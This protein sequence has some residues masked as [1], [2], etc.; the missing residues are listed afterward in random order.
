MEEIVDA[1]GNPIEIGRTYGYTEKS[2]GITRI[3][4]GIANNITATGRVT[5]KIFYQKEYCYEKLYKRSTGEIEAR[6]SIRGFCLFPVDRD[7]INKE[8]F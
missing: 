7:N 3:K 6:S 4:Y 5:M 8:R 2:S 1:L